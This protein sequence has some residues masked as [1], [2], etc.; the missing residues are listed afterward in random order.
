MCFVCWNYRDKWWDTIERWFK[1][2]LFWVFVRNNNDENNKF[3]ILAFSDTIET[4]IYKEWLTK[5]LNRGNLNAMFFLVLCVYI[6]IIL[7]GFKNIVKHPR[8]VI[9]WGAR[10][11]AME[12]VV[13]VMWIII[14]N[15]R[16]HVNIS[17][18]YP[19]KL[20]R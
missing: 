13:K 6:I 15:F 5:W 3:I 10:L 14:I 20:I 19:M 9:W 4:I 16:F 12:R 8:H 7:F 11:S 1:V 2:F 17:W 18:K